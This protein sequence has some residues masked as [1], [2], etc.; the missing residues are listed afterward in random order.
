MSELLTDKVALITGGA[1]G[2]GLATARNFLN[3]GAKVMISDING[4]QGAEIVQE[5]SSLGEIAFV[6]NNVA[7]EASCQHAV[8]QTV[9]RFGRL[10]IAVNNAGVI[11]ETKPLLDISAEGWQRTM[12]IN[13]NGVFFGLKAQV[14]AMLGKGGAIV[15]LA[16]M[17]SK[18][19]V[20]SASD[21]ITSKHAVDGLTK[22]AALDFAQ[23]GIRINAVG[24]AIIETP[25]LATISDSES[26]TESTEQAIAMHPI[27][28]LGKAEE[29]ASLITYLAS[30]QASFCTGSYY[31]V[32]GGYLAH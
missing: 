28:R 20:P 18:I 26:A 21:Y 9:D 22:A 11:G 6:E 27:G 23:A 7:D 12:D 24:P 15:N 19:A 17:A 25:L 32:N 10:D 31:P 8:D 29:V 5:L 16:S 1:S 2:I 3:E 4:E 14:K 30:D 13:I